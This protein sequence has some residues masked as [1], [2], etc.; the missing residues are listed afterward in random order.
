MSIIKLY[1]K[2][3]FRVF[4]FLFVFILDNPISWALAET[5]ITRWN[6]RISG[7]IMDK[8]TG[9]PLEY[10]TMVLYR[11]KDSVMVNGAV[12]DSNGRFLI[13]DINKGE[14]Y[15]TSSFIGYNKKRISD[16]KVT[17]DK[18]ELNIGTIFLELAENNLKEVNV[19][20][21]HNL[22]ERRIDKKVINANQQLDAQGG[23]AVDLL[24]NISSVNVDAEGNVSI[25]GSSNFKLLIDGRPAPIQGSDG[26]RQIPAGSVGNIEIITNP[27]A[28]YDPDGTAGIVN[29]IL[30][31]E[32]DKGIS[33]AINVSAGLNQKFAG[34]GMINFRKQ[35][36]N[37]FVGLDFQSR[38]NHPYSMY[39]RETYFGDTTRYTDYETFRWGRPANGVLRT[40][41][42]FTVNDHN[43]LS[44]SADYNRMKYDRQFSTHTKNEYIP[45]KFTDFNLIQDHFTLWGDFINSNLNFTHSFNQKGHEIST[46]ITY[47]LIKNRTDEP[48][49]TY[50]T[51]S[52]FE[53]KLTPVEN[54]SFVHNQRNYLQAKVDYVKPFVGDYKLEAGYQSDLTFKTTDFLYTDYDTFN[55]QWIT[56]TTMSNNIRFTQNIQSV[57]LTFGGVL[58]GITYQFGLRTEYYS[59][60]LEQKTTHT[61]YKMDVF[62]L[63]PT[64][65]FTHELPS[66]QEI[67]LGYSRRVN[68]PDDK[69]LNPFVYFTDAYTIQSGNQNLQPE[70][71][72]SYELNYEKKFKWGN[73][74]AE[75]YYRQTNNVLSQNIVLARDHRL[76]LFP[77]NFG[78]NYTMGLDLGGN[79]NVFKWWKLVPG[80]SLSN[81]I[82]K[83]TLDEI[84][85]NTNN[86]YF[87]G[88]L[89][90]TFIIKGNTKIQLNTSYSSPSHLI[91]GDF[92]EQYYINASA[93]QEFMKKKLSVTLSVND[94]F[95]S[96]YYYFDNKKPSF[97]VYGGYYPE[98]PVVMLSLSYKF[99]DFK[100]RQKGQAPSN[101]DSGV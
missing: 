10:S 66:D 51:T 4:I 79:I 101:L 84:N 48:M 17:K 25:R 45:G 67:Q 75:S 44:I 80:I 88:T 98:A 97:R 56:D 35:K 87:V 65:R 23:T 9:K 54:E 76:W 37:F 36:S 21:T 47:S 2:L 77:D 59:R 14:Y 73:L 96:N 63:F 94:I 74:T 68:R 15:L 39:H 30:K 64:V 24:R 82:Q 13:N 62:N 41:L 83:A 86:N 18:Q 19:T 50:Q 20:A 57:Y 12:A 7:S 32:K 58:W 26:L 11:S 78:K 27:S 1:T 28:K 85:Y 55:H 69:L 8:I 22:V 70:F 89:S 53:P 6:S 92:N 52:S 60:N 100:A 72:D 91:E 40:G 81:F 61:N 90:T 5:N 49:K 31:K 38:L 29:V 93:R 95:R 46:F 33:G 16:L 34:D 99:N 3:C 43:S 42:D 71:I